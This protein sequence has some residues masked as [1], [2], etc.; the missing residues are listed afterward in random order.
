MLHRFWLRFD[1]SLSS[2]ALLLCLQLVL[3]TPQSDQHG[4]TV[5]SNATHVESLLFC[6]LLSC[7]QWSF[8]IS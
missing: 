8:L 6:F 2:A 1:P 7:K 3:G 5:A 4:R